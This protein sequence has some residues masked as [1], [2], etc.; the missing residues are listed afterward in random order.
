MSALVLHKREAGMSLVELMV[1]ML[2]GLIGIV[3]ITHLYITNDRYKRSTTGGGEAQVNGAIALY[4]VEREIRGAGYGF[5]QSEAL[6]CKCAGVNCSPLQFSYGANSTFPPAAAALGALTPRTAA[7]VLIVKT[8]GAPDT[9][10]VM[11]GGANERMLPA[12]L[13]DVANVAPYTYKVDGTEGF[14]AGNLILVSQNQ[15]CFLK[16]VSKVTPT[17]YLL[18]HLQNP[19]FPFNQAASS[20]PALDTGAAVFNLGTPGAVG[21]PV[22]RTFFI[23]NN[24]LQAEDILTTLQN[25][26]A[27]PLQ[28]VDDIVDLQAQYGR[29]D[30][31]TPGSVAEDYL[32]DLWDN[33]PPTD[34]ADP[35]VVLW[36][37]VIAVRVGLLAR[38]KNFEKPSVAG[39]PCEATQAAPTWAGGTFTVPDGI[40]SCYKYRVFQT[41]IPLRNMIWRPT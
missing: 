2:I 15:A 6:S 24:K 30:G 35:T 18:D 17:N 39:G 34:P 41:V 13:T 19:Q 26:V 21:G 29:D 33:A 4:T 16:Q 40:P 20:G 8:P 36:K 28:L 5:N 31:S 14:A 23:A 11:Y 1:G 25:G 32:L 9:I 37:Q 10:T 12:Q 22:W 27:T 3:I 7:P 38:S